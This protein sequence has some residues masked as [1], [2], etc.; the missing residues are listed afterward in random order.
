MGPT[1]HLDEL[2]TRLEAIV[3]A[4]AFD[5]GNQSLVRITLPDETEPWAEP[6]P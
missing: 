1:E 4:A 5:Y 2:F 6:L 3:P